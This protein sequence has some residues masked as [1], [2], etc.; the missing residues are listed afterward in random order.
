MF[1]IDS[2][3]FKFVMIFFCR[4][5]RDTDMF[6]KSDPIAVLFHKPFASD[7]W[8]ELDRTEC[9]DNTVNPDFAKKLPIVY[10]F[11]EQQHIK[12]SIY[13]IDSA[14][15]KIDNHDFLGEYECS[16]ASLVSVGKTKKP[17]TDKGCNVS[18]GEIIIIAEELSSCKEEMSIKFVGKDLKN[19]HWFGGLFTFL[20]FY[21]ANEDN[22]YTLVH[23]TEHT[24]GE[25]PSW[26]E[27]KVQLR[28]FCS[29][30]YDRTLKVN[31]REFKTNGSHKLIGTFS[32]NVRVLM[33]GKGLNSVFPLIDDDKKVF[34]LCGL[35][36]VNGLSA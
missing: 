16:L 25:T 11:E 12:F 36:C 34:H 26:K 5:L 7:K 30:D 15:P 9:I 17:L 32:T 13:D 35:V 20:E 8:I 29:G 21:K 28:S 1:D 22:S 3:L 4:N 2:Y 14:N 24:R 31:C 27:F 10:R 6:S 18:C 19:P 23:R 33:E